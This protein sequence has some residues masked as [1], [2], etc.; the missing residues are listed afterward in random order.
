M[1]HDRDKWTQLPGTEVATT[2]STRNRR[3]KGRIAEPIG[4]KANCEFYAGLH[5]QV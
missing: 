4:L 1:L 5:S 3:C 2:L